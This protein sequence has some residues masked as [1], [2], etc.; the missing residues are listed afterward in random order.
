MLHYNKWTRQSK[1][2]CCD[3]F[4]L[5]FKNNLTKLWT[6]VAN[7][8]AD[9]LPLVEF[10]LED[11]IAD[12]EACHLINM[13]PPRGKAKGGR[14]WK[15]AAGDNVQTLRMDDFQETAE[16]SDPFTARL[17]SFEVSLD[18]ISYQFTNVVGDYEQTLRMADFQET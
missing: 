4:S 1:H 18:T 14:D 8:F 10:V 15:E 3:K 5:K 17:L 7:L 2:W 16:D 9:V 12:D 6:P 13:E 11:D